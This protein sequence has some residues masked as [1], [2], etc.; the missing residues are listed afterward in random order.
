MVY[1]GPFIDPWG[2][3]IGGVKLILNYNNWM[4]WV[5]KLTYNWEERLVC[6]IEKLC[7]PR[8]FRY[9]GLTVSILPQ[10]ISGTTN[11]QID[12]FLLVLEIGW[13]WWFIISQGT[14]FDFLGDIPHVQTH[15]SI[16]SSWLYNVIIYIYI[17]CVCTIRSNPINIWLNAISQFFTLYPCSGFSCSP[18]NL[19]DRLL[20]ISS[21]IGPCQE[22]HAEW[23]KCML[24][25]SIG[26]EGRLM[27][28]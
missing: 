17:H 27:V 26:M 1:L 20:L 9:V 15:P 2:C 6:F 7:I 13:N 16:I 8:W 10:T 18:I 5:C 21:H 3:W 11:P 25:W 24:T 14:C 19:K 22:T 28:S 12:W 4:V 23:L